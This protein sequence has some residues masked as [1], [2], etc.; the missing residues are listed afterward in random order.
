MKR[1]FL[2]ALLVMGLAGVSF[3]D[4]S[5]SIGGGTE[6][7]V[8]IT[9]ASSGTAAEVSSSG[10][11]NTVGKSKAVTL[12]T[13]D[14]LIYTG[15]CN[16]QTLVFSGVTEADYVQ[17]YDALTATG[18]PKFDIKMGT[19]SN[20]IVLPLGGAPFATGIY[21]DTSAVNGTGVVTVV[22]DY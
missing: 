11:V 8:S 5:R 20:T 7:Y 2:I 19:A 16:I 22:Y 12:Q 13:G 9:D 4:S 21:A 1:L 3:A 17:V 15:A 18:T 14:G 6:Q 10:A